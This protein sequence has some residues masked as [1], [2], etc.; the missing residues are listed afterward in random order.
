MKRVSNA[1]FRGDAN[2]SA[3]DDG[4]CPK[5]GVSVTASLLPYTVVVLAADRF[6]PDPVAVA[7]NASCKVMVPVAGKPMVMRV[8]DALTHAE[9]VESVILCGPPKA[10][11][12]QEPCLRE[13]IG[14]G[15]VRWVPNHQTPSASAYS[16]LKC[17]PPDVPVLLT[18]GDH[19]MLSVQMIDHFC[20]EARRSR[21]DVVAGFVSHEMVTATYPGMRRTATRFRDG[22]I[23]GCNLY[24]FVTPEG[25]IAADIWR[26]VEADRKTPWKMLNRL[27]W[28]VAVKY[29]MGRLSLSDGLDH[30]S[31]RMGIRVGVI[32]LPFPEASVD[33]DTVDDWHFVQDLMTKMP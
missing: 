19:A 13:R 26:Q 5:T 11:L 22:G 1:L 12:D 16:V 7:G 28:W 30:I 3:S 20:R 25:R 21:C 24:A 18:T 10:V 8:L 14:S 27:G 2:K 31:K 29:L 33:V 23:C 17:L 4:R 6:T 15:G 9:D 32:L